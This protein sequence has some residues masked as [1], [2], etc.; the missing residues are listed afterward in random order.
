MRPSASTE[1]LL[2]AAQTAA[3]RATHTGSLFPA[4]G[5]QH[6]LWAS[7]GLGRKCAA[8][9]ASDDLG[10]LPASPYVGETTVTP[11]P[12]GGARVFPGGVSGGLPVAD[13]GGMAGGD[14]GAGPDGAHGRR[15]DVALSFAGA[16]RNYVGQVAAALKARGVRCFYAD[17][18][19]RLWGTAPG[20]G[21][22]QDLRRGVRGRGGVHLRG[23]RGPGLDP[24][25]TP[26]CVQPGGRRELAAEEVNGDV[27]LDVS[28]SA[29]RVMSCIPGLRAA[30]LDACEDGG[31]PALEALAAECGFRVASGHGV[32]A[33]KLFCAR[34]TRGDPA[35]ARR[36]CWITR[37]VGTTTR[38]AASTTPASP[39]HAARRPGSSSAPT[40]VQFSISSS[41]STARVTWHPALPHADT[42]Q[43]PRN[44]KEPGLILAARDRTR[45]RNRERSLQSA[46]GVTE[47]G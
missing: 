42:L 2:T 40:S 31:L 1:S 32:W 13:S 34:K 30:F 10:R 33:P 16:Q 3:G 41:S 15:W 27:V 11:T 6:S 5:R 9:G 46:K 12:A 21:A 17:E 14:G 4:P 23:L 19:V 47:L 7:S 24:A 43:A 36:H 18:Q 8:V 20:R 28:A 37:P 22:A 25:G 44:P 45:T 35:R 26:R 29:L 38:P 39:A